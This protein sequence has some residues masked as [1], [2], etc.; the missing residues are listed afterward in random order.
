MTELKSFFKLCS[1]FCWFVRSFARIVALLNKSLVK[2]QPFHHFDS[3]DE[4]EVQA[5]LDLQDKLL[6]RLLLAIPILTRRYKLDTDICDT[7]IG[8]VLIQDQPDGLS[9]VRWRL[10]LIPKQGWNVIR[11]DSSWVSR[12]PMVRPP[13]QNVSRMISVYC[14][15]ELRR[16]TLDLEYD[17]RDMRHE[18]LAVGD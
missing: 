5:L 11:H 10:V 2:D 8:C 1:V 14:P 7:Q 17:W 12:W 3:L 18:K 9:E 4:K 13:V 16:A 6:S 15:Y